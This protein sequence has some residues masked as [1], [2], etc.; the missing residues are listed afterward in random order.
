[1]IGL[2][3]EPVLRDLGK[4]GDINAPSSTTAGPRSPQ[5][6]SPQITKTRIRPY[7]PR[8]EVVQQPDSEKALRRSV[9]LRIGGICRE[10]FHVL[11]PSTTS[12]A[13]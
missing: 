13:I 2:K 4:R 5:R 10:Y 1:M 9:I 6:E 12:S 8:L 3:A 7:G 11:T